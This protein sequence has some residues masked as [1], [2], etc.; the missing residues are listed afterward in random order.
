MDF[1]ILGVPTNIGFVIDVLNNPEFL[2]GDFH[3]GWVAERF[4]EPIPSEIPVELGQLAQ[5]ASAIRIEVSKSLKVN[6]IK[7]AWDQ[8]DH[9]RS[10]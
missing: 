9:F 7:P 2:R 10:A 5:L 6:S 1:H 4:T 8:T 3:T